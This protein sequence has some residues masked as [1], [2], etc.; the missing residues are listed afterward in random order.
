MQ[1][2]LVAFPTETVYGLGADASSAEAVAKIYAAKGRPSNHPVIVHVAK[3]QDI[4]FWCRDI[5]RQA[6]ALAKAFWPGPL[7]L[8]LKRHDSVDAAVSGGQETIGVRCPSHPVAHDLLVK[9]A[10]L[11]AEAGQLR[12]GVAAPSANRFGRVSPTKAAH[13]RS[14]FA[15]RVRA[16]MPV[17]DGGDSAVGIESTIVDLS[18]VQEGGSPALLRP[19][20]ISAADISAVLGC[21]VTG[22]TQRSP[23]VSGS[24]KAHYAPSTPLTLCESEDFDSCIRR[25]LDNHEGAVAVMYR[26]PLT[27]DSDRIKRI[28]MPEASVD[29]ARDLYAV[30]R[31]IDSLGVVGTI[32]E[33]VPDEMAWAGVRDRLLRAAAAFDAG[34]SPA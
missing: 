7:T 33:Q 24:L 12:S 17:L 9:F 27:L 20:A 31:Q 2:E 34:N 25:W 8:I 5:P 15:D 6:W 18:T 22:Q 28:V 3:A 14:E 11:K 21:V 16:G 13:V 32:V 4:E 19:G 10:Q 1:G 26:K 30:L 23:R 29:Y